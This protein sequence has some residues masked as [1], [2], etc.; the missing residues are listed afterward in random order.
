MKKIRTIERKIVDSFL[1]V[2]DSIFAGLLYVLF[3]LLIET[4]NRKP[5]RG[6]SCSFFLIS[7]FI[8]EKGDL[9]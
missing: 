5:Q 7:G 1:V 3:N 6:H 4:L 8:S 2:F 9:V